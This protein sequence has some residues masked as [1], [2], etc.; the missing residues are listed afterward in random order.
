MK[1]LKFRRKTNRLRD[2]DYSQNGVYLITIC[3]KDKEKLFGDIDFSEHAKV[4]LNYTGKILYEYIKQ[5]EEVDNYI[6]M[7]NH[8]HLIVNLFNDDK[9]RSIQSIVSSIKRNL[10]REIGY[11]VFQKSFHDHV[12]KNENEYENIWNYVENNAER[13]R[14]DCFYRE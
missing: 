4:K 12:I 5:I 6:I 14:E 1:A 13:W 8:I 7:P 3:T 10:T 11:S 2:Y 9:N